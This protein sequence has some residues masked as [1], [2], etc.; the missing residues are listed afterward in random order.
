MELI[1]ERTALIKDDFIAFLIAMI[2][3]RLVSF[4]VD[5]SRFRKMFDSYNQDISAE[6]IIIQAAKN[7]KVYTF[8]YQYIIRIDESVL[9]NNKSIRLIDLCKLLNYGNLEV[10]G[11]H[12]FTDTFNYI[13]DNINNLFNEYN[14]RK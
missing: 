8:N 6:N 14:L 2:K 7:L 10:E 5:E 9:Y 13:A 1:I 11:C 12:I 4:K 3:S